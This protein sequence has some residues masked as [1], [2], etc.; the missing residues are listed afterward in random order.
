M[1]T[2]GQ[3]V[4]MRARGRRILASAAA[5]AIVVTA[6]GGAVAPA[7]AA[8]SPCGAGINPIVC[9]NLK[10]GADPD[11]WDISGAGD[12]SIQGFA[13]DISV[14]AGSSIAF[15]IDTDATAYSI[16][17]YRTGWYQGKGARFIQSVPVT[18]TLPQR[19]DECISDAT[20]ELY[21]CG[22]WA[23]SASWS[24]PADAVSGV[25]IAKLT[26]EDTGG[27][28][29]IIFIVRD[30]DSHSDVV[31]Q[32]SDPTWQA[33]NT[34]GGSDFYQGAANG[35]SFKISY[36]RPFA[37]RGNDSGRDFYF[38]A[39]Y[40]T[41][42]FLERN[43]YDMSYISGVDADRHGSLLLNHRV[44]LSV[45]H[46]E[47]W[48][49]AQR[50]N[51]EAARDAG[52]NLQFLSG[53]EVY[54]RT[55]YEP[56]AD[57]SATPYRTLVSYKETWANA[58]IDPAAE[59]TGTWRDPR[60]AKA[61]QGGTLP[62]NALT[63]TIYMS[64]NTDLP[65]TVSSAE[66]RLRLWRH[67]PLAS[68]SAGTS[69]PLAAHTIGYESDEDVDNGF[70]PAGLIR[71]STTVGP[72]PQY[73][74]DYGNVVMPGTTK[75][76]LTLY[77]A[78]SGA[79][80][81]GAGTVQW[82]W[83]LD[84]V[85]DGD[86]APADARMQQAQV[87]LL[88][89]MG[90]QPGSLM[91][92]LVQAS[93]STDTTPPVTTITAPAA[94]AKI[95]HGSSVTIS[96]TASDGRRVAGV[97]VSVDGGTSW[98]P[99]EGSTSWTYTYVQ[100]GKGAVDLIAR[101]VDDSGNFST[102][103][104]TVSVDVTGPYTVWGSAIPTRP[105]AD[106][107]QGVEVGLRFT[108]EVDGH[109][110]GVRFYK[111]SG[112]TGVHTGSL[113][114]EDGRR[115]ASVQFADE[116][117]VGWQS[118]SFSTPVEVR[119]GMTYVVSYT[120]PQGGY[121]YVEDYW[122]YRAAGSSPLAVESGVGAASPAV[123][124]WPGTFPTRT[125]GDANYY[126]DVTFQP[127]D[128]SPLAIIARTP[129]ATST[130]VPLNTTVTA[131]FNRAVDPATAG[132]T[133]TDA[134]GTAV[135]G[136][137]GYD[138]TSRTVTL[139]PTAQLAAGMRYTATPAGTDAAGTTL[140]SSAAWTFTTARADLPAG[141]CP[142]TLYSENARPV[143]DADADK[144]LVTLG[145]RFT[146]SADGQ[147][148][149]IK[150]FKGAGSSGTHTGGLWTATGTRLASVTFA[151]DSAYGWQTAELTTP[152]QVTAGQTYVA[153]Y[154]APQGGYSANPGE[155][156]SPYVRGPLTVNA[157]GGV[158]TY[159]DGFPGSSS[160]TSYLVEVVFEPVVPVPTLV[161]T[162]PPAGAV[163]ASP[164]EAIA[165]TYSAPLA[166]SFTGTVTADGSAV[167]GSWTL[168]ADRRTVRFTPASA[169]PAGADVTVS[170]SGV[171]GAQG[172]QVADATWSFEVAAQ[173]VSPVVTLRGDRVPQVQSESSTAS[174]ELGMAF[175]TAGAGAVTGIRFYKS[176]ANTGTHTGSLWGPDGQRLATVTFAGESASGWQRAALSAPVPLTPGVVYT[177]SYL[178][179]N[180]GYSY[181][182][183]GFASPVTS[184][185]LTA[186][187]PDN[188]RYRYGT[189]GVMP[190][191][192]WNSTDYFVDVEFTPAADAPVVTSVVPARGATDVAVG[193]A[194]SAVFDRDVAGSSPQIE[195]R[196][197]QG[198]SVTGSSAYDAATRRVT[199]TPAQPLTAVTGYAVEVL[200]SGKRI[201]GWTFTTAAAAPVGVTETLFGSVTPGTVAAQD[202]SPVETGTAFRITEPGTATAIRFYKGAGNDG[203]HVGTLWKADGTMLAQVAFS[204]ESSAG[205]QRAVLASPVPLEPGVGYVVSYYAPSGHYAAEPG[206]FSTERV[207]G[208]VIGLSEANGRYRYGAG[209]GFPTSSWNASAYFVDAEITFEGGA[210]AAPA[211]APTPTPTPT[212][213]PAPTPTPDPASTPDST[214]ATAAQH[215]VTQ[216]TSRT[217]APAV[218]PSSA[219]R[220]RTAQASPS[221]CPTTTAGST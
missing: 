167:P 13:T 180:G 143:I 184:G 193:A 81:F 61:E 33:Y 2:S 160:T 66:G 173:N 103:G 8:G 112:N 136:T 133:L 175:R 132:L 9:E 207:N 30:D 113:W 55:R 64:N 84:Q 148:T 155:F 94:G 38:S 211:P 199:F 15:K 46:D 114:S 21:D 122:P 196:T 181:T 97:E 201:E 16:D 183:R 189:G 123:Y 24:V 62:E 73:L 17:V 154:V 47:Y 217:S 220:G 6:F 25:Y 19:Q 202:S 87:N 127:A 43:G 152:V 3:T 174:V 59:W 88:A 82:G 158:Y 172:G 104:T 190:T 166:A 106:D 120:A 111:G 76:H 130:S 212:P 65:I 213:S 75:H 171:T 185:P 221:I 163:N 1:D 50:T 20:T 144:A 205:W 109:V 101:A 188:G 93:K 35:R 86:G 209:G 142:C 146:P 23:V 91:I 129:V 206:Y 128:S 118:A 219:M 60:L 78:P 79:L 170:L 70:R 200:L 107:T 41:V 195:L 45:G 194:V 182:P 203:P 99:A 100:Q 216:R 140:P 187:S 157:G 54:W 85:H 56:S 63:G 42:R 119:A 48:S 90:A 141:E 169:L 57:A 115:L 58:K 204:A 126:V 159:Q 40:A 198:A 197:S 4:R 150:Y 161:A 44:F 80:V 74:T 210:A 208:R 14:D 36:N 134:D 72:T 34:Y 135:Q 179:P 12:D 121:A 125:Y 139:V 95:P 27:S 110:S 11:E 69:Q 176:A 164:T 51:V 131:R 89:D 214:A 67:T 137:V 153:S 149:A 5:L 168:D 191:D 96:G 18:A 28:S 165:A 31:F 151:A 71:L 49:G 108:P 145:V 68:M 26:R 186:E 32:T 10:P 7:E 162:S 124:G 52:V 147:I 83:G 102:G 178:A 215:T 39:E 138:A 177:V 22:S 37:T 98:H 105:S 156:S 218:S 117:E 53:N 192:G 92:G 116:T 77:R 29:H